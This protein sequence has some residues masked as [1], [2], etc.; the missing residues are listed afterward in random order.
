MQILTA[1]YWTE[2]WDPYRKNRRKIGE[3]EGNGNPIGRPTV[4]DFLE[5]PESKSLTKEHTQAS[6]RPDQ[7]TALPGFSARR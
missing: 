4:M 3:D 7:G 6:L 5:F 2:V 1:K